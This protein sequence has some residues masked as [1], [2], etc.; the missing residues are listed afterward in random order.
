[1]AGFYADVPGFRFEYDR[2][3]SVVVFDGATT[4]N[5]GQM[6]ILNDEFGGYSGAEVPINVSSYIAMA[7]PEMRTVQG[8]FMASSNGLGTP[9]ETMS[10][11]YST[12]TTNGVD[13]TWSGLTTISAHMNISNHVS[14]C[15]TDIATVSSV[16]IRGLQFWP[17]RAFSRYACLHVYGQIPTTENPEK[18]VLCDASGAVVT[19]GAYFD[20]GDAA[21]NTIATKTFR[22]KNNSSFLT[23]N[24]V[25]LSFQT[26]ADAS[27]TLA[28]QFEYSLDGTTWVTTTSLGSLAPGSTSGVISVR[29]NTA[30][31]AAIGP[32]QTRVCAVPASMT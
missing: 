8:L 24:S 6:Q 13:G 17:S 26:L 27:P 23:A 15:R 12:N 29:R 16:P 7:W 5:T 2:D 28:G 3:G 11:N 19:N 1:M 31:G 21:R 30:L 14:A 10:V 25:T 32:W 22:I 20:F 18:L 4:L 9:T